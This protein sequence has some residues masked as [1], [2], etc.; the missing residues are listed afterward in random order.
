M[1]N[2]FK[3]TSNNQC[4]FMNDVFCIFDLSNAATIV[5]RRYVVSLHHNLVLQ[6]W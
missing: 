1:D 4:I 2:V 5:L 6:C 3:T